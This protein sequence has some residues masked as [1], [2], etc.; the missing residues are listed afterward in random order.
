M[1]WHFVCWN[2]YA[3][4][5]ENIF[6]FEYHNGTDSSKEIIWRITLTR[7]FLI[8]MFT[9]VK[10]NCVISKDKCKI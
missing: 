6:K 4:I 10:C 1:L 8:S 9:I 2:F 7:L 5:I 3:A